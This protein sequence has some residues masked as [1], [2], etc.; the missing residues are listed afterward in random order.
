MRSTV[1][2]GANEMRIKAQPRCVHLGARWTSHVM[3]EVARKENACLQGNSGRHGLISWYAW[4]QGPHN[5]EHE[6]I[7]GASK[8]VQ[9]SKNAIARCFNAADAGF[10][11]PTGL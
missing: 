2:S 9:I 11:C 7:A 4:L 5:G 1:V 3:G 10:G 6:V 8:P